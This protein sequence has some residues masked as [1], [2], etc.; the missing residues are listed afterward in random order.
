[1]GV[2]LSGVVAGVASLPGLAAWALRHTLP[3][4]ASIV[5]WHIAGTGFLVAAAASEHLAAHTTWLLGKASGDG[6]T[7]GTIKPLSFALFWPYHAGLR[8]KLAIQRQLSS[9]PS[10]S[11]A[12]LLCCSRGPAALPI[13]DDFYIG[14]WPSE[15]ALVPTVHPAVLDVTCELPL[16]LVPPAYKV[17]PVWDTHA[18]T[19]AQIEEGVQWARRQ[20]GDRRPVLIHCA[21]G[22][23]RSATV[24]AAILIA[25]GLAKSAPEAEALAKQHRPRV[26]LNR[27]QRD[28]LQRWVQQHI[29]GAKQE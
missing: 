24:L 28:A 8:A 11:K 21:H 18:P 29:P 25:E 23:G 16:Q 27:R 5:L 13:T 1:M 26:R 6:R 7:N 15:E 4:P 10:F 9:E 19:V 22:H 12:R 17:L 14:A 3:L 2:H 20:K